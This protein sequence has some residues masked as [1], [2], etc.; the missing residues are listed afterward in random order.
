MDDSRFSMHA[1]KLRAFDLSERTAKLGRASA[2]KRLDRWRSRGFM[3]AQCAV[4]AG[5]AWLI[6][7]Q[8]LGHPMPFF[9]PVAA[10]ISLG[11]SFGA[12]LRRGV[13]VAIG[14]AV[15]VL[16]GDLFVTFF[17]TGIWQII[18]VCAIAM[19]L[20]TLLGAGQ[21]MIIQAGVQS[22]IVVTLLPDPG[23]ALNRW[24]DAV[25]GCTAALLIAT[26]APS[27]PLR[28]PR[29]LAAAA[30]QDMAAALTAAED[31]L[32]RQDP[33]AAD[34][35]LAQ[36]RAG[37]AAMEDL[38]QAAA[39][40]L[41]V[42]RY[43]PFRRRDIPA[44]QAY[45]DLHD[46][47]DRTSRNLRVLARRCA[48]ALWRHESVPVAY[49]LLMQSLA[50]VVRF[51]SG[52]LYDGRLPTAAQ[53]RLI[54]MGEAS[55]KLKLHDSMSSVVIL[56]QLRSMMVDLLELCGMTYEEARETIPDMD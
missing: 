33:E 24:L 34:V 51:M 12:R 1:M 44:V 31:A 22:I 29:L 41:A 16:V 43:S 46:P 5:L 30:L 45:A 9:A 4:T 2:R 6:A 8:V 49:L 28:R 36:A 52:E 27:A 20:A 35:V 38:D 10:I 42:V 11:F 14:V 53:P 7:Q 23:Q 19:S 25:I 40:G 55:S 56:A 47:L 48:I 13:E 32:R 3:I 15:G 21:L 26:I 50:E 37:Q 39:E 54:A 17:G 18:L